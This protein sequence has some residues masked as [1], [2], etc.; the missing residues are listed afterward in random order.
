MASDETVD[1]A[2]VEVLKDAGGA[3]RLM[4]RLH[5]GSFIFLVPLRPSVH[6]YCS[7]IVVLTSETDEE[8]YTE[9]LTKS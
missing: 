7:I 4:T 1:I 2:E 3:E 6:F 8:R 5:R 9:L